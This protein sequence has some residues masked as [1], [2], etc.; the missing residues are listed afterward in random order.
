MDKIR[1]M[2][3][4]LN[5]DPSTHVIPT[6]VGFKVIGKEFEIHFDRINVTHTGDDQDSSHP[7]PPQHDYIPTLV[8]RKTYVWEITR[9]QP[10]ANITV[11]VFLGKHDK[12]AIPPFQNALPPPDSDAKRDDQIELLHQRCQVGAQLLDFHPLLLYGALLQEDSF[13]EMS[14][15]DH[16]SGSAVLRYD[17][18]RTS[19][20]F[21]IQYDRIVHTA[22]APIDQMHHGTVHER[23]QCLVVRVAIERVRRRVQYPQQ[24]ESP[25]DQATVQRGKQI[26]T[27]AQINELRQLPPFKRKPGEEIAAKI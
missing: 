21:P 20:R 7:P 6:Q 11:P 5:M 10:T 27:H 26:V 23:L 4:V 13:L 17:A 12:Q 3:D 2:T 24:R 14:Y 19:R 1:N 18:V 9:R 25:H 16:Y 22:H 15:L 8:K